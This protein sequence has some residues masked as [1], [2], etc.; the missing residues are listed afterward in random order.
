[1]KWIVSAHE[2]DGHLEEFRV[3]GWSLD[4]PDIEFQISKEVILYAMSKGVKYK[5]AYLEFG[6]YGINDY[7]R[8]VEGADVITVENADGTYDLKTK[9]NDIIIDNLGEIQKF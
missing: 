6:N 8:Y 7:G 4:R 2:E 1:M 3:L 9:K 5:T